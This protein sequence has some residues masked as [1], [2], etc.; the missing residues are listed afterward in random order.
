MQRRG[1]ERAW[2]RASHSACH[3][4]MRRCSAA[5]AARSAALRP[6]CSALLTTTCGSGDLKQGYNCSTL[7]LSRSLQHQGA[8]W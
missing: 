6:S 3:A 7:C 1:A 8:R 2:S 4:A 5:A